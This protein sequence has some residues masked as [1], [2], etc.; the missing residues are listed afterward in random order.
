M[1]FN[2]AQRAAIEARGANLLVSA[3]AGS[4]KTAVL[5]ERIVS[6]LR[7]GARIDEFLVVTFT[8]AAA[9][10]MRARILTLLANAADAGE[11]ALA[12]QALRVER[13][14]ISTLHGFCAQVCRDAFHAAQVDPTFRVADAAEADMLRAQAMEE[15]LTDCFERPTPA[16]S[17]AAACLTQAELLTSIDTLHRFLMARPDPWDFLDEAIAAHAVSPEALKASPWMRVLLD[18]VA[19]DA[20]N[21]LDAYARLTAFAGESGLFVDFARAEALQAEAFCQAARCGHDALLAHGPVSF[22]RRPPKRKGMDEGAVARFA[23]LRDEAKAALADAAKAAVG[24]Q[25]LP[26]LA[27]ALADAG[28]LLA[29]LSEAVRRFDARFAE[30]KAEKN[31]VD[32]QDLEHFALSALRQSDVAEAFR[33]RYR[34]VF[35]DEYQDSSLLQEAILGCVRREDNLFLVGDVKQSIYRFRLAEPSLFLD[36]LGA[37]SASSGAKNRKIALNANYRSHKSLLLCVNQVFERVFCGGAMEIV[38]DEDARLMPGAAPDWPGAPVELHLLTD[39]VPEGEEEKEDDG[40]AD[41]DAELSPQARTSVRREAEIIAERILALRAAPEGGYAFGDMAILLRAVRSKAAQ[42]IEVLLER[43]IPAWSDLGEDA[44]ER[45]EVRAMVSLLRAIDSLHLD[46]P[47]LAALRGPALGLSDEALAAIRIAKPEGTFAD[48][49]FAYARRS[50]ELAGALS[51][52]IAR[53]RVWAMDAR[54]LPLDTLLRRLYDDTGYYAQVGALPDGGARQANLRMLAEHARAYQQAHGGGLGGFLRYLDRVRAHEG[55]AAQ[56]LGEKDDVVRVLSI[57]KSKGLQFPVVFLAGLGARFVH[58]GAQAPL[59]AHAALGA[60]VFHID[61]V[62]RT[63]WPTVSRRA[64]WEKQRLESLAEEARVLYVGMT[65]AERRLILVGTERAGDSERW[66]EPLTPARVARARGFLDWIA[67]CALSLP[68]WEVR[69]HADSRAGL[70]ADAGQDIR[71]LLSRVRALKAPFEGGKT[72]AALAWRAPAPSGRPLKQSV[73]SLVRAAPK[74][75]EEAPPFV[76]LS[77]LPKR[78][79]F[80]EARGLTAAERGDAVHTFLRAVPLDA[81]DLPAVRRSLVERGVLSPEQADALPMPKLSRCLKSPLWDRM[82]A[83]PVLHRERP[84]ILRLSEGGESTLLQGVIDCCFLE[85]GA[86][87][88]VDYKTDRAHDVPALIAQYAPQLALYARALLDITG[89]PVKERVLFLL[90]KEQ[91]FAL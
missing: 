18:R 70:A 25:D 64:I 91:G 77:A 68:G 58:K 26:A 78:P 62:L 45:V 46:I 72:A 42:V 7:E 16:F 37:F 34:F 28:H 75:G 23:G 73:S 32:F 35:V 6:L 90:E 8:K 30:L 47:L 15:A 20:E 2:D 67:P 44:L 29:G 63:K 48:A 12:A 69:R 74:A 40:E 39:D 54:V 1:R 82:R 11:T 52:F 66:T 83:A 50:D 65:R 24:L 59:L 5:A 41:E 88:L 13:A 84:F 9:A 76:P 14:D 79:L 55:T 89:I 53:M 56:A 21:A 19:L 17:Y 10:E 80:L 81:E 36:K 4:G 38:Y 3:A 87:V 22:G 27:D 61:P 31:L 33:A 49:V 43:G 85:E 60:G 86:W 71:R 51:G 57:H